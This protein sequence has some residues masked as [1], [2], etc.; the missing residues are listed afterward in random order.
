M[1]RSGYTEDGDC[2]SPFYLLWPSIVERSIKGQRGQAFLK[3]LLAD[4]DAMPVKRLI[5]QA[6]EDGGEVCAMGCIGRA[7][8][9]DMSK[10]DPEDPDRIAKAFG[11]ASTLV[12]E[13]EFVNDDDFTWKDETPENRWVR[14]RKWVVEQI[15]ASDNSSSEHGK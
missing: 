6:L 10:L 9:V 14:V 2:D 13:I 12:R 8:G 7:R 1:S 11:I 4:L 3:E 5:E 15:R